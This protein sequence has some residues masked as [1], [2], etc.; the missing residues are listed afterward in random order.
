MTTDSTSSGISPNHAPPKGFTIVTLLGKNFGF[1]PEPQAQLPACPLDSPG[2]FK[3]ILNPRRDRD[4]IC[5]TGFNVPGTGRLNIP[6]V[7][8]TAISES[9]DFA[10]RTESESNTV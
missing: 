7:F 6:Q 3:Y 9:V 5:A 10:R 8:D 2:Q 4:S 1:G